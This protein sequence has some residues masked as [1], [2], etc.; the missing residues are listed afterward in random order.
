MKKGKEPRWNLVFRKKNN[1]KVLIK[2][3]RLKSVIEKEH[4]RPRIHQSPT[5]FRP[6]PA[7][8]KEYIR[9]APGHH[10]RLIPGDIRG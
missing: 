1:P 10:G 3:Q 6:I 4:I 2:L 8:T 5:A 9:K 7:D